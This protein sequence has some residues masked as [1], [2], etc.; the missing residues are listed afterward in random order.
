MKDYS[1]KNYSDHQYRDWLRTTTSKSI[2]NDILER[3]PGNAEFSNNKANK[4]SLERAIAHFLRQSEFKK[5]N[6]PKDFNDMEGDW[7]GPPGF[8]DPE[9]PTFTFDQPWNMQY[10]TQVPWSIIFDLISKSTY[11][12]GETT[13]FSIRGTHPIYHLGLSFERSGTSITITSGYGTNEVIGTITADEDEW[14]SIDFNGSMTA[15]VGAGR[16][17]VVGTSN[18]LMPKGRE[19]CDPNDPMLPDPE[20]TPETCAQGQTVEVVVL[21][22]SPPYTWS[23]LLDGFCPEP[24]FQGYWYL[25]DVW[26]DPV[27]T[28]V[29]YVSLRSWITTHGSI[30]VQCVD[31]CGIVVVQRLKSDVGNWTG[32]GYYACENPGDYEYKEDNW[33]QRDF[34][35]CRRNGQRTA[36]SHSGQGA[37]LG[38]TYECNADQWDPEFYNM[39]ECIT[40]DCDAINGSTGVT[41]CPW[42]SG[43]QATCWRPGPFAPSFQNCSNMLVHSHLDWWR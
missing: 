1:R 2:F 36:D 19:C 4:T 6:G 14:S 5:P 35:V 12:P 38:D 26:D 22:G 7:E 11:C 17:G 31:S 32:V 20:S 21:G 39:Y 29:P 40:W 27:V 42:L 28:T 41:S 25:N 13:D 3:N 43:G 18:Y 34:G 24:E 16:P 15:F 8:R 37:C 10:P 23:K 9:D 30:S 33:L